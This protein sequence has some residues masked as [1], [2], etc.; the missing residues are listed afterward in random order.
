LG[1]L[2]D[3]NLYGAETVPYGYGPYASPRTFGH[4]G[5]QSSMAFADPEHELVVVA[6]VNGMPGERTHDER[7]R[8][9]T[10]ALYRDLG[11]AN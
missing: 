1:F 10:A 11:L 9:F 5:R 4:S 3:S 2:V 7:M 8:A 6:G